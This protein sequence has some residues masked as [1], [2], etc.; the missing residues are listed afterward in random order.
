MEKGGGGYH[1][2]S[3]P[4]F[5]RADESAHGKSGYTERNQGY[6]HG[7]VGIGISSRRFAPPYRSDEVESAGR[8]FEMGTTKKRSIRR[9]V[10]HKICNISNRNTQMGDIRIDPDRLETSESRPDS[11]LDPPGSDVIPGQHRDRVEAGGYSKWPCPGDGRPEEHSEVCRHHGEAEGRTITTADVT[12]VMECGTVSDGVRPVWSAESAWINELSLESPLLSS[13]EWDLLTGRDLPAPVMSTIYYGKEGG[14]VVNGRVV[15]P[16]RRSCH[17]PLAPITTNRIA[18]AKLWTLHETPTLEEQEWLKWL[19]GIRIAES[20][21]ASAQSKTVSRTLGK[22]VTYMCQTGIIKD[23]DKAYC[24]MPAFKVPK[25][26]KARL[27]IDCR[28]LNV[29]LP[30]PPKMGIESLHTVLEQLRTCRYFTQYD[31]RSYFYQFALDEEAQYFFGLRLGDRRGEFHRYRMTVL[32]M[33]FSY[34]PGIAQALSNIVLRNVRKHHPSVVIHCWIDN[35]LFGGN[36]VEDVRDATTTF[37]TICAHLNLELKEAE[38]P[39]STTMEALGVVFTDKGAISLQD[40]SK[41]SLTDPGQILTIRELY[42]LLGRMVWANYAVQRTSLLQHGGLLHLASSLAGKAASETWDSP[43]SVPQHDLTKLYE[44]AAKLATVEWVPRAL[45]PSEQWWVDA[46]QNGLGWL[47]EN[48]G[49]TGVISLELKDVHI[50]WKELIAIWVAVRTATR[51]VTV[52]TDSRTAFNAVKKGHTHSEAGNAI[53]RR[54]VAD[55]KHQI[56]VAW[57]PSEAQKADGISRGTLA[58]ENRE[59]YTLLPQ[60]VWWSVGETKERGG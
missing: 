38:M 27:I 18:L 1:Q 31:G 40:K 33:G 37:K 17:N 2:T 28:S 14:I 51:A 35:F 23:T 3:N 48:R 52:V 24:W 36:S 6:H 10:H 7:P 12:K 54:L 57:V 13:E 21:T 44:A 58:M 26:D 22:D 39:I 55:A 34:A 8:T 15:R 19:T 49:R 32:P 41:M 42:G 56:N 25:G 47:V 16:S 29:S 43:H 30:T 60:T 11:P 45:A 46:S 50:N 53:M 20:V 59:E 9:E 4:D 5:G